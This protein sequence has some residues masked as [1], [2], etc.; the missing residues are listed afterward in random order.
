MTE[1]LTD[2]DTQ[3]L[4]KHCCMKEDD[5]GTSRAIE[6]TCNLGMSWQAALL[7][8]FAVRQP[9]RLLMSTLQVD[10]T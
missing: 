3:R 4:S 5:Q 1:Y 9:S 2:D 10:D 6:A 7:M 8:C